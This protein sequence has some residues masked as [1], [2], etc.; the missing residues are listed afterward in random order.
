MT[1]FLTRLNMFP[2]V[3]G[4][5]WLMD[6]ACACSFVPHIGIVTILMNDYPPLKVGDWVETELRGCAAPLKLTLAMA[7]A[8]LLCS[9]PSWP[10]WG[11]MCYYTKSNDPIQPPHHCSC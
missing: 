10:Y 9:L 2:R 5:A 4:E 1:T 11:P 7:H 3:K 6:D 8:L